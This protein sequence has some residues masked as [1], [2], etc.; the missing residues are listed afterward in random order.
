M[1]EATLRFW[2]YRIYP[3]SQYPNK[4][5]IV[6]YKA[7]QIDQDGDVMLCLCPAHMPHVIGN[8]YQN[9]LQQ[10]WHD[11]QARLVRESVERSEFSYCHPSCIFLPQLL[12]RPPEIPELLPFPVDIKIDID[13]S[14]N[15]K[16]ATCR[17]SVIIEKNNHRIDLQKRLFQEIVDYSNT[18]PDLIIRV[19]PTASGEIFASHSGLAFLEQLVAK[20]NNVKIGLTTNGTLLWRN[21]DLYHELVQKQ[22]LLDVSI[23]IDA[24]TRET[25]ADIRG[26]DWDELLRGIDMVKQHYGFDRQARLNF[27]VQMRNYHEIEQFAD[28]A[29]SIGMIAYFQALNNWGHWNRQW[30]TDNDALDPNKNLRREIINTVQRLRQKY[31][32]DYVVCD[33][34]FLI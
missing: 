32:E 11:E 9:S 20:P 4:F 34:V 29:N 28:W 26:G 2:N 13:R 12:D 31:G 7:V 1:N 25:Y 15:L 5:C 21:R 18:N 14:C 30:W 27:C 10:I 22:I 3:K 23:S 16:C 6:P 33:N 24:A 8:V 19:T 17:E